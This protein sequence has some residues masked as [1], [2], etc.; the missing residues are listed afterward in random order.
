VKTAKDDLESNDK[1]TYEPM[2]VKKYLRRLFRIDESAAASKD[3]ESEEGSE[4]ESVES[5]EEVAAAP[6]P[7]KTPPK[8]PL[9]AKSDSGKSKN[10]AVSA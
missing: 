8:K 1:Y 7:P 2:F 5:E 9:S 10:K 4:E 3:A 6:P